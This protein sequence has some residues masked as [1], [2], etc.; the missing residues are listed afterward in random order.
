[1]GDLASVIWVE[2]EE[3]MEQFYQR[4][5]RSVIHRLN[6]SVLAKMWVL[7]N[8][9][10]K[11]VDYNRLKKCI[12]IRVYLARKGTHFELTAGNACGRELKCRTTRRA[13]LNYDRH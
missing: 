6:R 7:N 8:T 10:Q 4:V 11:A 1:M 5:S 2:V 3:D 13:V 12:K 9:L